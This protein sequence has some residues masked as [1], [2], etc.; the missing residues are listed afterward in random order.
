[1]E[2]SNLV[3]DKLFT[4]AAT[5]DKE[6][7]KQYISDFSNKYHVLKIAIEHNHIDIVNYILKYPI[8]VILLGY[9]F[10]TA[11]GNGNMNIVLILTNVLMKQDRSLLTQQIGW[12]L[13]DAAENGYLPVVDHILKEYAPENGF[14][15]L[16]FSRAAKKGYVNIVSLL[17]QT[18]KITQSQID[19]GLVD[20][21]FYKHL[22][23]VKA[24]LGLTNLQTRVTHK[25]DLLH[26]ARC[27]NEMYR[28]VEDNLLE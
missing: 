28:W 13:H 15:N 6:I 21:L 19:Y 9:G 27:S 26:L 5:G 2:L 23:I 20:G 25:D 22:E 4:A 17:L 16:A 14:I 24:L 3:C 18:D 1:M 10:K 7:I 11:C 8:S 12:G